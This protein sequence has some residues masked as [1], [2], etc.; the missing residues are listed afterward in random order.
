M[1]KYYKFLNSQHVDAVCKEGTLIVSS[2]QYFRDLEAKEGQWIG[3]R[4]EGATELTTSRHYTLTEGSKELEM[5]NNANIGHGMFKQFAVMSGGG[6]IEMGPTSFVTVLPPLYVFSFS[7][8]KLSTLRASMSSGPAPYDACLRI[9][10]PGELLKA[11]V[12]EG[13]VVDLGVSFKQLFGSS[14]MDKVKYTPV[15][16]SITEGRSIPPSPF[17]KDP[18][19]AGQCEHR[20]V[21]EPGQKIELER[22]MVRVP[23]PERFFRLVFSK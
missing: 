18:V 7:G 12:E 23:R 19:F 2:L 4:L 15:S 6:R 10:W 20:M 11:M 8:G 3:D 13:L 5:F 22:L 14:G 9:P 1:E 16:T 17:L 21:F